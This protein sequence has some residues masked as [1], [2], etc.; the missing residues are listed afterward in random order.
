MSTALHT[1]DNDNLVYIIEGYIRLG[2][3]GLRLIP[4]YLSDRTRRV[5]IDGIMYDFSSMFCGI[6][7][8]FV[9]ILFS[10]GRI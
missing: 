6:K 2:S 9:L 4:S 10:L 8:V 5:H 1:I 3:S 7:L